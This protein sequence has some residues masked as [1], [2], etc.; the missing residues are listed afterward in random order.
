MPR[1]SHQPP[2]EWPVC[3]II[4]FKCP[5]YLRVG[6]FKRKTNPCQ[7]LWYNLDRYISTALTST[8]GSVSLVFIYACSKAHLW[9][10]KELVFGFV[11]HSSPKTLCTAFRLQAP[12]CL[13]SSEARLSPAWLREGEIC[14]VVF[15]LNPVYPSVIPWAKSDAEEGYYDKAR[16]ALYRSFAFPGNVW[17]N[18]AL[19]V[20]IYFIMFFRQGHTE[21]QFK[22]RRKTILQ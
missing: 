2:W 17:R 10:V 18:K 13:P 11:P 9:K 20:G 16:G 15:V 19:A 8:V 7:L 3:L 1:V 12:S 5:T 6:F 22:E 14:W 21:I 4:A